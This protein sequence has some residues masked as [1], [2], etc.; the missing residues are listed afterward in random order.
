MSSVLPRPEP[1][2][3]YASA[4]SRAAHCYRQIGIVSVGGPDRAAF[5]Q[6]Q[7]TQDVG[8]LASGSALPTAGLSPKGKI[9]Y[10]GMV[11][12]LPE[13][14][15]L[16]GEAIAREFV[17]SHLAKFAAFQKVEVADATAEFTLAG[18]F[19]PE[20]SAI[21][22]PEGFLRL[23]P[24]GEFAASILGPASRRGEIDQ[25]LASAGSVA[26]SPETAETLRIEAG[27]PRFG[28]EADESTLPDEIHLSAAISKTK[29]CYVGQEVVARLRTYGRVNRRLVGFRF[30]AGPVPAGTRF[31]DPQKPG[32]E[33]GRV[34]SAAISPRFGRIGLGFAFREVPEGATLARDQE[35][36]AVV[37]P[38]PFT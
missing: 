2:S 31:P 34:T 38:L 36:L 25:V 17:L 23:P 6:G 13:R 33:L 11:V 10:I 15:L 29:G 28:A 8:K 19:G 32:H 14:L 35:M 26:A 16:I 18:L 4:V 30:P 27:R 24:D 7:L 1:P 5:L 22:A 20:A 12:A 3:G 9:I 21:A 37:S